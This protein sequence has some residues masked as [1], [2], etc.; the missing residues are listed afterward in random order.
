MAPA[1][2]KVMAVAL[3]DD[4]WVGPAVRLS[5]FLSP[6]DVHVNRS[7]M[8]ALVRDVEYARGRFLAAYRPE[9]SE[10]NERCTLLLEGDAGA[11]AVRQIAGVL[12]RRIVCRVKPGDKLE[13][14]AALRADPL[15]VADGS[16]RPARHGRTGRG[17]RPRAGGETIM[18]VLR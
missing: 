15:R 1:D 9:A 6:L 11:V 10:V 17:G 14:G 13:R 4:H 2:G 8:A 18:A 5:I 16:D 7:P 12:A 3:V